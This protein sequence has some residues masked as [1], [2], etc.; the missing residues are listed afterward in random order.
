VG[1]KLALVSTVHPPHF[2]LQTPS[3]N[4]NTLQLLYATPACRSEVW[5]GAQGLDQGRVEAG[6]KCDKA[7]STYRSDYRTHPKIDTSMWPARHCS[8]WQL[9]RSTIESEDR[10]RKEERMRDCG[11]VMRGCRRMALLLYASRDPQ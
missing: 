8:H 6:G 4:T 11:T 9:P 1:E 3:T 10:R 7:Y 2:F 5:H